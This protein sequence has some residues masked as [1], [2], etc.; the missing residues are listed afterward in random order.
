M[1][2]PFAGVSLCGSHAILL[3]LELVPCSVGSIMGLQYVAPW[4]TK[5]GQMQHAI[6]AVCSASPPTLQ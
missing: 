3:M 5:R 2:G 4:H 6:A 1:S